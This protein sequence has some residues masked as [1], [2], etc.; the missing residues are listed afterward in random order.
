MEELL[1]RFYSGFRVG[2]ATLPEAASQSSQ[3]SALIKHI[4]AETVL[5]NKQAEINR[6]LCTNK[7]A[8]H[9]KHDFASDVRGDFDEI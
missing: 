9:Y 2:L 3:L 7:Q 6:D 5:L 8:A 4:Y 1:F